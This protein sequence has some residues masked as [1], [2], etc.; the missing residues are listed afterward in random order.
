MNQSRYY[1]CRS[2]MGYLFF[3]TFIFTIIL[4]SCGRSKPYQI[5]YFTVV[6]T[7]ST[8][9]GSQTSYFFEPKAPIFNND[10][11]KAFLSDVGHHR[12][13][14]YSYNMKFVKEF[15]KKGQ[16]PNE[17][18]DAHELKIKNNKLYV[19]DNG[20]NKMSIFDLTGELLKSFRVPCILR[21][22]SVNSKGHI[23]GTSPSETGIVK[24]FS[25]EG[26]QLNSFGEL[27]KDS[28]LYLSRILSESIIEIDDK[29]N[30]YLI[31]MQSPYMRKYTDNGDLIWS[32]D[33]NSYSELHKLYQM[34]QKKRLQYPQ[35][36]YSIT[37]LCLGA[38]FNNGLLHVGYIGVIP[39]G[40]TIYSFNEE[41]EL[42]IIVR[43]SRGLTLPEK[44]PDGWDFSIGPQGELW[45]AERRNHYILKYVHH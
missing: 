39:F 4:L 42:K 13:I 22:F 23:F 28:D 10:G 33:L 1:S 30:V 19:Y 29:D 40:N 14:R 2:I 17:F 31:L 7:L 18:I 26:E 35:K 41:G 15:G 8:I 43:I 21:S 38:Q 32:N 37:I 6:D 3:I 9:S 5:E 34:A 25:E 44:L 12:I 11:S 24:V 16:G 27:I 45:L 20:N 36:K